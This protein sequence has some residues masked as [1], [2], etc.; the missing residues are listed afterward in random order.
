MAAF[1]A[2]SHLHGV[3]QNI[4]A[5]ENRLPRFLSVY[6]LFC[7]N[8]NLLSEV[9][10]FLAGHACGMSWVAWGSVASYWRPTPDGLPPR[11]DG[12]SLGDAR[13]HAE[14]FLF[15]HNQEIFAVNLDFSAGILSEQ[16]VVSLFH[17][18]REHLAVVI[19]PAFA[20]GDD[21]ALQRLVLSTV[22]YEDSAA[23]GCRFFY[24]TNQYAVV[25]RGEFRSRTRKLLIDS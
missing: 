15:L 18:Q 21:L 8:Q 16:D 20:Y 25:Q 6:D 12:F 19:A 24:A 7:H 3:G 4:N 13:Q 2:E 17:R 23:S 1:G 14:N 5:A 10:D 11:S 22:R 9:T